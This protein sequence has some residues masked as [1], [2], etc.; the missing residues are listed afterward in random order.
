MRVL[1]TG[2]AGFF[3]SHVVAQL[4]Q[5]GHDVT[6][7]DDLSSGQIEN[8][9]GTN[10]RFVHASVN[11]LGSVESAL[12]GVEAVLHMAVRNVRESL[13]NPVANHLV[14]DIGTLTILEALRTR[15]ES[16]P[17]VCLLLVIRGVWKHFD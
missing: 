15:D 3:G 4:T 14:N 17:L 16:R 2:G 10:A 12:E 6:V 13:T 5:R 9:A 7:L 1:V 8:I 11:D